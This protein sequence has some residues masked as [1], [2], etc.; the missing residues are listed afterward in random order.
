MTAEPTSPD[1]DDAARV[2]TSRRW[3]ADRQT[4]RFRR[5][6]AEGQRV[7][8]EC[9]FSKYHDIHNVAEV[10]PDTRYERDA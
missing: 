4:H 2:L 8:A 1:V 6:P 7:C 10:E 3:L 5:A 9:L